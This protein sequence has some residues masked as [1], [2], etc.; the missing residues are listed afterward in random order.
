MSAFPNPLFVACPPLQTF[1]IDKDTGLPLSNGI[2]TFFEDVNRTSLKPVYVLSG[3]APNY[4]FTQ[5]SSVQVLSNVGTFNYNN[6]DTELY[7][8]P[9][10]ADGNISLYY[11]TVTNA[12]GVP[13]FTRQGWPPFEL[14]D[15][16]AI[17]Q[18]EQVNFIPNGQFLAHFIVPPTSV[19]SAGTITQPIT[20]IAPGGFTFERPSG[21]SA[22]DIV[23]FNRF[24]SYVQVPSGSPR[25]E[26]QVQC[27]SANP[28]DSFKYL[29]VK[30]INVNTF[31]SDVQ[32][33]TFFFEALSLTGNFDVQVVVVK[34]FGT[35]GSPSS[36]VV[37][38]ISTITLT[39]SRQN[40][41]INIIFGAN[42]NFSIGTNDDDYVQVA[43]ALPT[44][45]TFGLTTTDWVLFEGEQTIQSFPITTTADFL[46]RGVAGWM[47]IPDPLGSEL[48]LYLM[49]TKSGLA[50]DDSIIGNIIYSALPYDSSQPY[51]PCDGSQFRTVAY[52]AIG[53]PYSRLQSK[54]FIGA[55]YNLPRYGTGSTYLTAYIQ[56]G[57][58]NGLRITTNQAGLQPITTT[59]S[60]PFAVTQTTLGQSDSGLNSSITSAGQVYFK[61]NAIGAVTN[62]TAGTMAIFSSTVIQ[63]NANTQAQIILSSGAP[64]NISSYFTFSTTVGN[65][66]CWFTVNGAGSN[67]SP[68]GTP[69]QINT[70]SNYTSNEVNYVIKD[71]MKG[72][73]LTNLQMTAGN[74]IT[75]GGYISIYAASQQYIIWY[76]VDGIGT[77]PSIGGSYLIQVDV[78]STDSANIV[79]LKTQAAINVQF[80]AVPNANN[81]FLRIRNGTNFLSNNDLRVNQLSAIGLAADVGSFQDYAVQSHNHT[82]T[83]TVHGQSNTGSGSPDTIQF[84]QPP[85]IPTP[86]S[87]VETLVIN[88]Y[89]LTET[90]SENLYVNAFIRY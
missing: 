73:Q 78:L 20:N 60:V 57:F 24:G 85:A 23:T 37:I 12:L 40:Y 26:V 68:G 65:F 63:N 29:A 41:N 25:Y 62:P 74:T 33:Y 53:I 3:V 67:P 44:A 39:P 15:I 48:G 27:T 16:Q 49:Q 10:D 86:Q 7:L 2:V 61:N 34:N 8:Y 64:V 59:A 90:R 89:G 14:E 52:S 36:P 9:Y 56:D 79:A 83:V 87:Q 4:Q 58:P 51:L 19:T 6:R 82:G 70:L 47:P 43:I 5:V 80:F 84:I 45:N 38:P 71:A 11:V 18:D 13:Q 88:N 54:L 66:Y 46:T 17:P 50:W 22:T 1:F 75:A 42:T 77:A 28:A 72:W 21:S 55:P 31:S 81:L 32:P 35:G 69:I 76:T 30:W